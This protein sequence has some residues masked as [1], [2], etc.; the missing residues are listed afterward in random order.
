[1]TPIDI[2]RVLTVS[3]TAF[4]IGALISTARTLNATRSGPP[5]IWMT[6]LFVTG[7]I[8]LAIGSAW[9]AWMD[10]GD[11]VFSPGRVLTTIGTILLAVVSL[12][13]GRFFAQDGD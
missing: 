4:L 10:L 9:N 5:P 12:F 7:A 1:M 2:I 13:M 3:A 11:R 6:N 8:I